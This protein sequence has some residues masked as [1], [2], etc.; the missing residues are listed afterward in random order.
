LPTEQ[1]LSK[2]VYRPHGH[3]DAECHEHAD[4]RSPPG[5][6]KEASDGERPICEGVI[7][8]VVEAEAGQR[9]LRQMRQD[10]DGS[11]QCQW[12]QL[13]HSAEGI[14]TILPIAA[15]SRDQS[16]EW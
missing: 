7:R 4:Q 12:K 15:I 5:Y 14:L 13:P 9:A 3:D 8:P 2:F 6:R 1:R 11:A 10:K 16:G